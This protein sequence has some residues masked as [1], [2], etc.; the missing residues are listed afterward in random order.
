MPDPVNLPVIHLCGLEPEAL[1]SI[2]G[3][4]EHRSGKAWMESELKVE[5]KNL[6]SKLLRIGRV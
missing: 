4:R 1:Y 5:L 6:H 3:F 2:E